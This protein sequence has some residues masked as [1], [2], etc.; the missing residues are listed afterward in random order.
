M[1]IFSAP[2]TQIC[3]SNTSLFLYLMLIV[4]TLH[5]NWKWFGSVFCWLFYSRSCWWTHWMW[6]IM[7]ASIKYN[8]SGDY[9]F[10]IRNYLKMEKW[11][12]IHSYFRFICSYHDHP[13]HNLPTK[14]FLSSHKCN[15]MTLHLQDKY[16]RHDKTPSSLRPWCRVLKEKKVTNLTGHNDIKPPPHPEAIYSS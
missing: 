16:M 8:R 13:K 11:Q 14:A 2:T 15:V 9:G 12:I 3:K 10:T 1:V 4:F 7:A 6:S 5:I